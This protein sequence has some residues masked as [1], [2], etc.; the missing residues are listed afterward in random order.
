MIDNNKEVMEVKENDSW[1][2][3]LETEA[4]IAPLVDIYE[5]EDSYSLVANMPGVKKE[6]IRIKIEDESLVLM[7]RISFEDSINKKYILKETETGNFYRKFKISDSVD[8]S[9]IEAKIDAG[10][11]NVILPK[12]DRVKPKNI[13]IK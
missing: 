11:L 9:K 12:H 5:T 2:N 13:E 3:S 6:D 4:W 7:G 10:Q 1:E 8:D